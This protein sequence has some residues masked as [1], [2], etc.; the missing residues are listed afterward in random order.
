MTNTILPIKRRKELAERRDAESQMASIQDEMNRMFE[1]FFTDPFAPLTLHEPRWAAE[2]T[3]RVDVS[4]T[5]DAVKVSAEMPGMDEKDIQV[6]LEQDALILSGEKKTETEDKGHNFHRVERS[7][8]SFKRVI[9]LP[10]EVLPEKAE[11]AFKNGLLTVTLPKAPSALKTAH[12]IS[13][14]SS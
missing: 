7:C 4:E 1:H 11:A 8:G 9:P 5:D 12:K 2:F 10:V 14:K 13:I 6:T 3:P